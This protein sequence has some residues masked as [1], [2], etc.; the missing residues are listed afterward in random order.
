MIDNIFQFVCRQTNIYRVQYRAHAGDGMISF[1]MAGAIPH[2]SA[3]AI[4]KA[5]PGIAQCVR[6][7]MRSIAR[8]TV[9]LAP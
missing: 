3:D 9:S 4:A 6:K 8:L 2:K 5:N 7:L 1:Q